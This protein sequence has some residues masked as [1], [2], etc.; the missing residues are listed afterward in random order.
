L[1][2]SIL[3][4]A[5][6]ASSTSRE[7]RV[8][9]DLQ[10]HDVDPLLTKLQE[11]LEQGEALVRRMH[12]ANRDLKV[13][14]K[15]AREL[16]SETIGMVEQTFEE[17]TKR[18]ISKVAPA[19]RSITN[20]LIDQHVKLLEEGITK[21]MTTLHKVDARYQQAIEAMKAAEAGLPFPVDGQKAVPIVGVAP[22]RRKQ[23]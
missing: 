9:K 23:S 4:F 16:R 17:V 15:E 7:E 5:I 3:A 19:V 21:V 6:S 13:T 18:E 8:A 20:R 12:E 22:K 1:I 10:P 11:T 2:R 14:I